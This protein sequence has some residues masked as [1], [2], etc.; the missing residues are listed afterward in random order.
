MGQGKQGR[1]LVQQLLA[2]AHA[3]ETALIQTLG[4]HISIT[5]AGDYR[6][7]LET[8]LRE[9]RGHAEKVQRRLT[10][11]GFR[12]NPIQLGHGIAQNLLKN[13]MSL[14]KGP[15]DLLRGK[16]LEEKLVRNA[17]DEAVTETLE[18]ATYDTIENVA[19]GI[20]DNETA[21]LAREIRADEERM[22]DSLR[23]ILP[24]LAGG[25][26]REQ[27]PPEER[28]VTSADELA[29][30]GYADL[31]ADEIVGRL[32]GLAQEDLRAIEQYETKNA[33]RAT[34]LRKLESLRTQE[35]W[36]GYDGL[37]VPEIRSELQHAP[38]GRLAKV[39]EYERAHKNRTSVIDLTERETAGV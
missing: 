21:Q 25:L 27:V 24:S 32:N 35:P 17:R 9:T 3:A 1:Q 11:L 6:S 8:H 7:G 13:T 34:V 19:L 23:Q 31:T 30:N 39:R 15:V 10:D 38:E 12:K 29:I 16:S 20:G 2:E 22:L 37:T 28:S 26:V 14:A 36:P 5:P 33:N 18:I 4:A